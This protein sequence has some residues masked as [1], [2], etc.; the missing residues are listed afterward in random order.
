MIGFW[1]TTRVVLYA[2]ASTRLKVYRAVTVLPPDRPSIANRQ[3]VVG[4]SELAFQFLMLIPPPVCI[5]N[6]DEVSA[7]LAL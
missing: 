3:S 5:S 7:C 6:R 1:R 2:T 4:F